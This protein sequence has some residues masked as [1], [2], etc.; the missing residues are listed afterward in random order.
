MCGFYLQFC[1][2]FNCSCS[3]FYC[4]FFKLVVYQYQ[5]N[6]CSVCFIKNVIGFLEQ[7]FYKVVNEGG[8]VVYKDQYIYIKYFIFK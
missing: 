6:N 1:Q 4:L 8:C 2:F 3:L 5:G 7:C